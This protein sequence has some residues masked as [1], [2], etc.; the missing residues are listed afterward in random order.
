MSDVHK[1]VAAQEKDIFRRAQAPEVAEEW[2]RFRRIG[3]NVTIWRVHYS[4]TLMHEQLF[5]GPYHHPDVHLLL[6][7]LPSI[8]SPPQPKT[9][10]DRALDIVA[11]LKKWVP[12][13][14]SDAARGCDEL[15]QLIEGLRLPETAA[16]LPEAKERLINEFW[17]K[18]SSIDA[19][20]R[21]AA[22]RAM[23]DTLNMSIREQQIE[24]RSEAAAECLRISVPI[25][26]EMFEP[27]D[28]INPHGRL[29][30]RPLVARYL[31]KLFDN[32]FHTK[33]A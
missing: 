5:D 22:I 1:A 14:E 19:N 21:N 28:I 26:R 20:E 10:I 29:D 18:F 3:D 11:T 32:I 27:S 23:E 33:Y 25:V 8:Q 9:G 15:R 7:G 24:E 31:W 4:P 16:P 6:A 13:Q 2:I 17:R 12:D 30:P